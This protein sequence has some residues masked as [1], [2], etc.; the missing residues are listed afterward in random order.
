MTFLAIAIALAVFV[1]WLVVRSTRPQRPDGA[2]R[3]RDPIPHAPDEIAVPKLGGADDDEDESDVTRMVKMPSVSRAEDAADSVSELMAVTAE[4]GPELELDDS[5]DESTGPQALILV[6]AMARTDVGRRRA[7]NEDSYLAME[8]ACLFVVADGMGGYAGG[9]VASKIAVESIGKTFSDEDFV[10]MPRV[11]RY[12]RANELLHAIAIANMAI[13][14]AALSDPAHRDMGTTLAMARFAPNKRRVYVA[15][16]GDSRIYR[17]RNRVIHQLT[18]D[19]TLGVEA[20]V[21]GKRGA[22]LTRAVGIRKTVHPEIRVEEALPHDCF[23]VCSDG[24]NKMLSDEVIGDC[25]VS[26]STDVAAKKL[27][28]AANERGGRD[29][30]TVIVIRVENAGGV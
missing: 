12:R 4:D 14:M 5:S 17:V 18:R 16:V 23:V 11:T 7:N 6:T 20:G 26:H 10:G 9:E 15:N 25:V 30:V 22:H 27:I 13:L 28:E 21:T 1:T 19:H 3:A 29:N 2:V 8:E 24:L